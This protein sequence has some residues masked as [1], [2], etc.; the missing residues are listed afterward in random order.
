MTSNRNHPTPPGDAIV[1]S[2]PVAEPTQK[3]ENKHETVVVSPRVRGFRHGHG[4]GTRRQPRGSSGRR[5][6]DPALFIGNRAVA[7][8]Q[9]HHQGLSR[10]D[11]ECRRR[12]D[13]DPTIRK[14]TTVSRSAGW[15]GTVAGTGRHG[16]TRRLDPD[17]HRTRCGF[18]STARTLRAPDGS[19]APCRRR[20]AGAAARET[21]RSATEFARDRSVA[22]SWILQLVQHQQTA[23][24]LWRP[25]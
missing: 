20:Q 16:S 13:Q 22:R 4:G 3:E 23:E 2:A 18:L 11:R 21:D 17:R 5:T 1:S 7:Y 8:T 12:K 19:G 10:K 14:R 24:F 6:I 9:R 15:Q 25:Q